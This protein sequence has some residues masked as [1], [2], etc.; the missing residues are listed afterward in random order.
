MTNFWHLY[1]MQ[2]N[3]VK[4]GPP[5]KMTGP[6]TMSGCFSKKCHFQMMEL[7]VLGELIIFPHIFLWFATLLVILVREIH[8]K[9]CFERLHSAYSAKVGLNSDLFH[10]LGLNFVLD[11]FCCQDLPTNKLCLSY[12]LTPVLFICWTSNIMDH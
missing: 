8:D 7:M 10:K 1:I 9:Y 12:T 3:L 5:L 2:K 6:I 11:P 4:K